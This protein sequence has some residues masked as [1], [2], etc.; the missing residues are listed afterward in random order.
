MRRKMKIA[1]LGSSV[2]DIE[3]DDVLTFARR[4]V[5][6]ND[7]DS[8]V[9]TYDDGVCSTARDIAS[10]HG[11]GLHLVSSYREAVDHCAFA[12]IIRASSEFPTFAR[13]CGRKGKPFKEFVVVK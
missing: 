11:I 8:I 3:E 6:P 2:L 13:Y 5:Y 10:H 9:T 4:C 12:V 7:I 1:I